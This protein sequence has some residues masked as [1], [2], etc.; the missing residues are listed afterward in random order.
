M[1]TLRE[2][3]DSK[4]EEEKKIAEEKSEPTTKKCPYCDTEISIKAVKCPHCTS[5]LEERK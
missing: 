5:D 4:E 3:L 1:N 2:K